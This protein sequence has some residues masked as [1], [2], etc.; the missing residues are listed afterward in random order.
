MNG[1]GEPTANSAAPIGGPASWLKV[2]SPVSTRALAVARSPRWT[3]IGASVWVVVSANT[4]A[5]DSRNSDTE[6]DA[7]RREVRDDRQRE[8]RQHDGPQAVDDVRR[9]AAGPAVGEG[10]GQRPNS[11]GG[12]H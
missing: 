8:R 12:S 4:S 1:H 6:H 5:V 11:S 3:S 9:S 10:A 2:T 7:D